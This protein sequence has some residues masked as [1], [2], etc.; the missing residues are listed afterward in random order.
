M[1]GQRKLNPVLA[2]NELVLW[3]VMGPI[4]LILMFLFGF[5]ILLLAPVFV[6]YSLT[7]AMLFFRTLNTGYLVKSLAFF[8]LSVFTILMFFTGIEIFTIVTGIIGLLM[9]V[10]LFI[11]VLVGDFKWRIFQ[12]LELASVPVEDIKEGYSMRPKAVSRL[13][14]AWEQFPSF[15]GFIR[16][17]LISVVYFESDR[18]VFG[19][20]RNRFKMIT[21]NSDYIRDTWV[22][23][24]RVGNVS[25]HIAR[26]DYEQFND[27][28]AFDQLSDSLGNIFMD[29]FELYRKGREKEI[30]RKLDYITGQ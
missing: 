27:T 8:F 21:F 29:F 30:I 13:D 16:R 10:W 20:N 9:L 3:M 11:L 2:K 22:S 4:L 28:Y 25:V 6:I 18:V 14:Y 24:D 23:F 26:K 5:A 15:A 17:N 7:S 1:G 19:L 12:V